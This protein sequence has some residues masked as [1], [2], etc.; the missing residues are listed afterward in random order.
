MHFA[1]TA[2]QSRCA[3]IWLTQ[4]ISNLYVA[5]GGHDAGQAA[6]DSLLGLCQTKIFHSNSD[7]VTNQWAAN[8][9]GRRKQRFMSIS[10]NHPP[11]D[12]LPLFY[13][14]PQFST[15]LS[16]AFEHAVQPHEFARIPKGG[17]ANGMQA[18]A[19]V[20]QGGR[21]WSSGETYLFTSVKQ[22]F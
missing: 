17:P 15:G 14:S 21:V 10:V 5:L 19:I 6:A 11:V 18:G 2:R 13:Q 20:F 8:L 16:E 22:G 1:A 7:P 12:P 4:N 9:L 3:N